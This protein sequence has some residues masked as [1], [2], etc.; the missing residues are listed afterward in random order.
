MTSEPPHPIERRPSSCGLC[1]D[2][3]AQHHHHHLRVHVRHLPSPG[4]DDSCFTR[5]LKPH[6]RFSPITFASEPPTN[7]RSP[8]SRTFRSRV[9]E[10]QKAGKAQL[11]T[12]ARPPATISTALSARV[13]ALTGTLLGQPW[14]NMDTGCRH[15]RTHRGP[16]RCKTTISHR[17]PRSRLRRCSMPCTAASKRARPTRSNRAPAWSSTHGRRD[18]ALAL[19]ADTAVL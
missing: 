11:D 17:R 13:S 8:L 5:P 4:A 3:E 6:L 16:T 9:V 2:F 19:M 10:H 7:V 18:V 15:I 12:A 14:R 1:V